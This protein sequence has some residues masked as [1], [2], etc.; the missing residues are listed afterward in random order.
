MGDFM[1]RFWG[2]RG[3][4]ACPGPRTVRYGG[5]TPCVEV[6]CG[7]HLMIFDGGTGLRP[8][9]DALATQGP[10]DADVYFS[11]TH[12]DHICGIPFFAPAFDENST[13]RMWAGHLG[14]ELSL[15]EVLQS[16]MRPPL[17]PVPIEIFKARVSFIDF[18]AGDALQPHPDVLVRTAPLDHP[19]HCTGYRIEHAGKSVCYITDTA[20]VPGDPNQDILGLIRG[21]DIVIYDAMFTPEQYVARPGWG[22]STWQEGARLCDEAGAGQLVLFHHDP[23][24]DDDMLDQLQGEAAAA[25]PGTLVARE[26]LVLTP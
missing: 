26:G 21:A 15:C 14:P 18:R 24:H 25:R 9:G 20:H 22:H 11:H 17:F 5:N 13:F 2:V 1:V 6:R 10:I 4:I 23:G 12:F 7:E 3:S 8:L 19:D 16:M